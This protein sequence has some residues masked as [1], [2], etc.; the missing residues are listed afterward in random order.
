MLTYLFLGKTERRGKE[1]KF[2]RRRRFPDLGCLDD[3]F[4][5]SGRFFPGVCVWVR[6]A[7]GCT[8]KI[9]IN[10]IEV[11]GARTQT[12]QRLY[13]HDMTYRYLFRL[14]G[15]NNSSILTTNY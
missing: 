7:G 2:V 12:T 14:A 15:E 8:K 5:C 13:I 10:Q 3:V 4:F 9:K 11:W 6:A 1:K